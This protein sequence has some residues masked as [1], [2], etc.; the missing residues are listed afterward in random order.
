VPPGDFEE[1][2]GCG[3]DAS[4]GL[5][6]L[7]VVSRR[8]FPAALSPVGPLYL[9]NKTSAAFRGALG[10]NTLPLHFA[11][12]NVG[13]TPIRAGCIWVNRPRIRFTTRVASLAGS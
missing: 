2:S 1:D 4:R 6:F 13:G 3:P 11:S 7:S 5:I 8:R 12:R 10:P 9:A